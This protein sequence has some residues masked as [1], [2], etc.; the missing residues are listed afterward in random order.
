M[1]TSAE[2]RDNILKIRE[3]I[4]A[5]ALR[6]GRDTGGIKLVAATKTRTPYEIR[7]AIAAGIDA[8]GENRVQELREKYTEGAYTGAPLHFIGQL[9]RNKVRQIVGKCDLIESISSVE[10]LRETDTQ[11]RKLG[12]IQNI[13]LEVNIGGEKSKAGFG[14]DEIIN[15]AARCADFESV[16]LC[17]IMAIPPVFA[18]KREQIQIFSELFRLF[19]DIKAQN[20]DNKNVKILSCGMSG[21][22]EAAVQCG[23]TQVR[24]GSAIF[25]PREY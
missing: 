6:A 10:L 14:A 9:Q 24:I 12:I 16:R 2:I 1:I 22:Y 20:S 13:L 17:G 4:N 21:D 3:R 5:A 18:E 11:A 19:L 25:G 23:S 7:S 8:C 15:A